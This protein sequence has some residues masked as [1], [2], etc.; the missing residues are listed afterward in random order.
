MVRV[1]IG[2]L[3]RASC[4]HI[5]EPAR[6]GPTMEWTVA[7]IA[8]NDPAA[9][10]VLQQY[11]GHADGDCLIVAVNEVT[12]LPALHVFA[13]IDVLIDHARAR[14]L[15]LAASIGEAG[16]REESLP[17]ALQ[18]AAANSPA[19]G[20]AGVCA[21][22]GRAAVS[23]IGTTGFRCESMQEIVFPAARLRA[24][25]LDCATAFKDLNCANLVRFD[26]HALA[27]SA[28]RDAPI[29]SLDRNNNLIWGAPA[30]DGVTFEVRGC[31]LSHPQ[32]FSELLQLLGEQHGA[33]RARFLCSAQSMLARAA[34]GARV[35]D[36]EQSLVYTLESELDIRFDAHAGLAC[37]RH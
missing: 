36:S 8:S 28:R 1:R 13:P 37:S 18:C 11:R 14:L 2:A 12:R 4:H 35:R 6:S 29:T 23:A 9:A 20:A 30:H 33:E 34:R 26:Y 15:R 22:V 32:F 16:V 7:P 19:Y 21:L 31:E 27:E 17:A 10:Q 25:L 3:S 24:R 5:E